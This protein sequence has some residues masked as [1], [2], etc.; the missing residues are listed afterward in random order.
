MYRWAEHTGEL[1]LEIEAQAEDDVYRD[2]LAAMAELLGGDG[3]GGTDPESHGH[4]AASGPPAVHDVV[5]EAA[6]RPQ[7]L[8][9]FLS[10]LAFLS[11]IER[12][13]P[14]G[15]ERLVADEGRLRARVRGRIGDPPHLV[16][17]VTYHRLRFDAVDD[18]W[19]ATA[20][21]DV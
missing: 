1:E 8:A 6:D 15:I 12:F 7:L 20:V 4:A 16:K 5:V 21:L 19:R 17:A 2:A 3:D 11:E 14:A 13:V 18:G 10:E 9:E